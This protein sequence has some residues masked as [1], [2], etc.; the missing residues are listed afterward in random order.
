MKKLQ[1]PD[2]VVRIND[3]FRSP[4]ARALFLVFPT[5][6]VPF[7]GPS[8]QALPWSGYSGASTGDASLLPEKLTHPAKGGTKS[9]FQYLVIYACGLH[10]LHA[11]RSEEQTSE[12]QS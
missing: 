1:G 8:G 7:R 2:K 12:L 9:S 3:K 5:A 10:F 6:V 11:P 4:A